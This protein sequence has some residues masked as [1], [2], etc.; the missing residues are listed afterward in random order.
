MNFRDYQLPVHPASIVV[1]NQQQTRSR[2][3]KIL[4]Q[5]T[6]A[7]NIVSQHRTIF[8]RGGDQQQH[9]EGSAN[10]SVRQDIQGESLDQRTRLKPIERLYSPEVSETSIR[11][12]F[13]SPGRP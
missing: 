2:L 10:R 4:N 7:S 9:K 6:A 5:V 11:G 3:E 8:T 1:L 13:L 12:D